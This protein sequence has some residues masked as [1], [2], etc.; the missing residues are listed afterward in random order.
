MGKL[1]VYYSSN[2]QSRSRKSDFYKK[3]LL[4]L[5]FS[6]AIHFVLPWWGVATVCFFL[7]FITATESGN[8]FFAAFF[9]VF[10]IWLVHALAIDMQNGHILSKKIIALFTLPENSFLLVLITGLIGG[11]AGGVAA[12]AGRQFGLLM[13]RKKN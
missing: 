3:F 9:A 11:V 6:L 1:R 8:A 7:S 13:T 10:L 4:F 12:M 5:I 2:W